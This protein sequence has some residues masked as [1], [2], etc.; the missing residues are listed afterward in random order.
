MSLL[1]LATRTSLALS[2]VTAAFGQNYSQVNLVAN[3]G[4]VAPVTDPTLVNPWGLARSSSSDWWVNN[5]G[6]GF[7]TL[8]NGAGVKNSLVVTIQHGLPHRDT[9]RNYLQWRP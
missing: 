9:D 2:L 3:T 7:A 1:R 4:G 5:E 8:F 6:S